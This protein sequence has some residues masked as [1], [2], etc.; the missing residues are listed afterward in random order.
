MFIHRLSVTPRA[1][2]LSERR[3]EVCRQSVNL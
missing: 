1:R 2:Q 3:Y